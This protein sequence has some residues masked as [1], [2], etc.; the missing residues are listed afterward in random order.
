MIKGKTKS[1]FEYEV[2][3]RIAA[4][5]EFVQMV[6]TLARRSTDQDGLAALDD[7]ELFM[8]TLLGEEQVGS[9]MEFLRENDT[10]GIVE[11]GVLLENVME[12]YKAT[13]NNPTVK[14]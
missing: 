3:E 8:N 11:V 9:L 1:G 14:K 2:N 5:W 13:Q 10:D 12:I 7:L 4:D 6:K